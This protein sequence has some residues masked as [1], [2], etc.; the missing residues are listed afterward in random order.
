[1]F[2]STTMNDHNQI[3]LDD[4]LTKAI[5]IYITDYAKITITILKLIRLK[6]I[7][8]FGL[9]DSSTSVDCELMPTSDTPLSQKFALCVKI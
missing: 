7:R 1:M 2:M 8:L 3:Q 5:T 4:K 9:A 6:F